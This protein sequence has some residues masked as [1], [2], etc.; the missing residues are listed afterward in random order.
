MAVR[1][2]KISVAAAFALF[3]G[4]AGARAEQPSYGPNTY[5]RTLEALIAHEDIA[6]RGGWPKVPGSASNL[7]P[8]AQGPDVTILKQRLMLSGDLA[9]EAL[10][11]DVYDA[12]VVAA[13]KRF[14][15]R[16][17]LSDLGTIGRLTLKAM[18]VPVEVR[19]NQLTATLERLK[20]NGFTFAGRYVVVNIPGASVEAV[21]N[22][23]VQRRHLAVV[24]R[25]DRP[26]PVLQANITSVNLNPY[27][28][29]P[30]SIVKADIIPHMRQDPGFITKS[31][32]KLLG[33]E[34]KE[35]DPASVNWASLKSPYFTVR[36]EPGPTNSLGQLKIDMPNSEAVYMHDT[37]KKTLFRND[38]RFNS[39][40]C[41]RIE[42][43]RDLA[44]WLLEGT[45]WTQPAIEAEI[46]KN[47]RKNIPLKK[48]VPVAWVY[49][50]GWQ[51][52]DGLVQF[53]EDIYGLDTPQGIATS[54]IVA[55]KPKPKTPPL[56]PA[57]KLEAKPAGA[58]PA[59]PVAAKPAPATTAT[60]VN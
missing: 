47:E 57:Q 15:L 2:V 5:D 41:A 52:G 18:N 9:P 36:Q 16:H 20:S 54:T 22:G 45:E 51:S 17:G 32:M 24:G 39:S 35:I 44:A 1:F 55:R 34:N 59:K 19:L 23:V 6:N 25:S 38:V 8:D 58:V 12:A 43:V 37:P 33:A 4:A 50:T 21:E 56:V 49:L 26:S 27:W 29:V 14:Q 13:V 46:A 7:K 10:P 11:G 30:T 60:A 31:N 28:T 53:R 40:G 48:S 3:L 42:G